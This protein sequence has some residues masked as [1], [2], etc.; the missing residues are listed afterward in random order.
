VGADIL[1][2]YD[3]GVT[4][5]G[6]QSEPFALLCVERNVEAPPRRTLTRIS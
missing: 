4:W 6:T 5:A 2:S 3:G 1:R